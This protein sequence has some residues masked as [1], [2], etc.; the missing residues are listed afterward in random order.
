MIPPAMS[1][2]TPGPTSPT[3][4]PDGLPVPRRYWAIVAIVLA[5]AMSVLDST[6][7]NVA[8]PT[9][10]RDFRVSAA[11]SIWVIN[12]YQLAILVVLLPLASLGERIGYR[13]V[14]QAGL[15]VFTLASLGCALAPGLL[16]LS[17]ARVIQGFGAGAIMSVNPAL[18]RFTYPQRSLGRAVGINA[19]AVAIAAAAGPTIASAVLAVAQWR[20]LFGINVPLGLTTAL[21]AIRAL[22]ESERRGQPLDYTGVLL[23]GA[24]VALVL[25][26]LQ[27]LAHHTVT[28]LALAQLGCAAG[29]GW[30]LVRHELPRAAPVVP[31]DLL[32]IRLFS[33]SLATAVCA[34]MA[35]MTAFVSLPFEIQ[36]LGHSAVETGLYMTPWPLALALAAPLAGRLA[37]RYSAGILGGAGLAMMTAGLAL[38]AS[39]PPGGSGGAFAWRMA[40]CGAGFGFFQ[41]PNN[42]TLISSAPRARSGAAGGMLSGARLLGQ[43]VGAAGVAILFRL[44]PE[45]GSHFAL[46]V[47]ALLALAA[48]VVSVVRLTGQPRADAKEDR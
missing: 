38:L 36:R 35:Q 31:F 12:A 34:F 13:R 22:P 44:S 27:S 11:A 8:L 26:G 19:L 45:E 41:A 6:I 25:S 32:R 17:I 10:A 15:I 47:A 14:S 30:L 5:I 1:A 4:P 9:I 43:A 2:P 37:D 7:V 28:A 20:W 16:T 42:R 29:L 40:L 39:F 48:A 46:H 24:T 18:V 23:Y 21:I 33:L 3:A